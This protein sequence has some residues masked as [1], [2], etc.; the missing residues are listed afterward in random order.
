MVED[1]LRAWRHVFKYVL[2]LIV[3]TELGVMWIGPGFFRGLRLSIAHL[4]YGNPNTL[5]VLTGFAV[6]AVTGSIVADMLF[7]VPFYALTAVSRAISNR[8]WSWLR[9]KSNHARLSWWDLASY[10]PGRALQLA[11]ESDKA[12]LVRHLRIGSL[13]N[14]AKEQPEKALELSEKNIAFFKKAMDTLAIS[15]NCELLWWVNYSYQFTQERRELDAC[16]IESAN[17]RAVVTAAVLALVAVVRV[18]TLLLPTA[19]PLVATFAAS[20]AVAAFR[21]WLDA[22]QRMVYYMVGLV[23]MSY[24]WGD[25]GGIEDREAV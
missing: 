14:I 18:R 2:G 8:Q 10:H 19:V 12:Y 24:L 15:K 16:Q 13:A 9:N 21:A 17:A 23:S 3:A 1:F 4:V 6:I 20:A 11:A 22:K 25:S 7:V 5:I